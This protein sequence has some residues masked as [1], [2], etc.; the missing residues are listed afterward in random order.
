V[1]K[2]LKRVLLGLGILVVLL[3][4]AVAVVYRIAFGN[5]R[6]IVDR[7]VVVPGVEIVKDG[8][9]SVAVVD[10][11]QDTVA[12]VDCGNDAKAESTLAALAARKMNAAS[13]VAIFLTHGH[14]DHTNGCRAFPGA[15]VYAMQAEVERVGAAATVTNPLKDGD[16]VDLGDAGDVRVEAFGTPGHTEGSA[17]YLARGVL[18]FGDSAGGAKD[19]TMMPAV[20]L[21]SGN[22]DQNVASL[23]ALEA[24]LA[25]RASDIKALAFAHTGPLDG[26]AP[27]A[28]FAA[29]H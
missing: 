26:F 2:I 11:G 6:P 1:K 21:F 10:V 23:R 29:A 4:I 18:F 19:G 25:P 8:I 27:F 24:R 20:R 22:P 17:I 7:Q 5:N 16:A 14:G 15:K 12:L 9:V 28:A 13:V 3:G